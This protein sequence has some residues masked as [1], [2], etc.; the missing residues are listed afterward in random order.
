MIA[1]STW[2]CASRGFI[3]SQLVGEAQLAT[4]NS[5]MSPGASGSP[6]PSPF[7]SDLSHHPSHCLPSSFFLV[8]EGTAFSGWGRCLCWKPFLRHP[9]NVGCKS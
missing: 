7:Q 2:E 4:V 3:W 5:D 9:W 1:V 8:L 6:R